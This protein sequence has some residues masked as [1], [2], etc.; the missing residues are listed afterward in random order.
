MLQVTQPENSSIPPPP[1][2]GCIGYVLCTGFSSQQGALVRTIVF[3]TERVTANTLESLFFILFLLFFAL[4]AA[5]YVW[6]EGIGNPKRK[7]SKVLLDCI[8]IVTSVVPPELP[9]ELSLAVN[10][11]LIALSK[12]LL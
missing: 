8:L 7:Q 12:V 2:K 4:I 5:S 6:M 10:N 9:M 3:S 1:D 11:S